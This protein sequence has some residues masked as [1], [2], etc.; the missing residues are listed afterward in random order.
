MRL[1]FNRQIFFT[2]N[3][4]SCLSLSLSE[5]CSVD[6]WLSLAVWSAWMAA[7]RPLAVCNCWSLSRNMSSMLSTCKVWGII[8]LAKMFYTSHTKIMIHIFCQTNK[9]GIV[10]TC[11]NMCTYVI[12]N[13]TKYKKFICLRN[14]YINKLWLACQVLFNKK[15]NWRIIYSCLSNLYVFTDLVG[16]KKLQAM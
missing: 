16:Q 10:Y 3:L 2:T 12:S 11:N 8:F 15:W 5:L 13:Y 4:S 14:V 9:F 7:R 1:S 6:T